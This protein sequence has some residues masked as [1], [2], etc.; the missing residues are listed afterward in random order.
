MWNERA[1]CEGCG[2]RAEVEVRT[3][4]S[5]RYYIFC[6]D[7]LVRRYPP[8]DPLSHFVAWMDKRK[9]LQGLAEMREVGVRVKGLVRAEIEHLVIEL[10]RKGVSRQKLAS[11]LHVSPGRISQIITGSGAAHK[12]RRS[13]R[14][15]DS[16]RERQVPR[17]APSWEDEDDEPVDPERVR[18]LDREIWEEIRAE[19]KREGF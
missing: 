10:G 9:S 11:I 13:L 6:A 3:L 18:A 12:A 14:Q 1:E 19:R 15:A 16:S 4:G 17:V 8:S 7:C 5:E 2:G